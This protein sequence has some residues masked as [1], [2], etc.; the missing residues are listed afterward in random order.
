[1]TIL[2]SLEI[3]S[4]R[5]FFKRHLNTRERHPPLSVAWALHAATSGSES[6]AFAFAPFLLMR[7][8][9]SCGRH[10]L[11]DHGER[12]RRE[13]RPLGAASG[14]SAGTESRLRALVQGHEKTH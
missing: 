9:V 6:C 12:Q 7:T 8:S 11:Y 3:A 2:T 10:E 5:S 14:I 13:S 1:M 4:P